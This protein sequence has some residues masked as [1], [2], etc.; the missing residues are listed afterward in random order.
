VSIVRWAPNFE[1][2]YRQFAG[3]KIGTNSYCV[4]ALYERFVATHLSAKF[5]YSVQ[6]HSS[7]LP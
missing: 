3:F 6:S 1:V 5:S 4:R 2:L 7:I